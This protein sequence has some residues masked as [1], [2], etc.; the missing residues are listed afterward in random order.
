MTLV[1][2]LRGLRYSLRRNVYIYIY[3]TVVLGWIRS[4]FRFSKLRV[5]TAGNAA[6]MHPPQ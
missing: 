4:S 2:Y 3:M 1:A 6:V 5:K